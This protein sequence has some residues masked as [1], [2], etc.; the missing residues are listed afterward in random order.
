MIKPEDS[1]MLLID[2]Q[3]ALFNLVKDMCV[4]ELRNNIIP[5][6]KLLMESHG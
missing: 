2:H 3:S 5:N 4:S 1:V 6:Y